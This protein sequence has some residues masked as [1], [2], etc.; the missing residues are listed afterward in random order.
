[1]LIEMYSEGTLLCPFRCSEYISDI[2]ESSWP[3]SNG[4]TVS[5]NV[6]TWPKTRINPCSSFC[7]DPR[8]VKNM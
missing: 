2:S 4:R 8:T 6:L 3:C 7:K 5:G 1:M